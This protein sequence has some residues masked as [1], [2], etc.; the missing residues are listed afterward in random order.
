[1]MMNLMMMGLM[2][3][4]LIMEKIDLFSCLIVCYLLIDRDITAIGKSDDDGIK[5]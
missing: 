5:E 4:I 2:R 1:M 3:F